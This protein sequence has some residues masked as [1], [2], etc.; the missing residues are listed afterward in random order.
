MERLAP[1]ARDRRLTWDGCL[2]VRDLGG[3]RGPEGAIRRGVLVR[4][5]SMGAPT[6]AGLAAAREHGIRTVI[7]IRGADEI[8]ARPS[9]FAPGATYRQVPFKE[10]AGPMSLHRAAAEGTLAEQLRQRAAPDSGL[11]AIVG[12]IAEAE[13]GLIV[14]C[15]AGRDRTGFVVAIVLA[16]VGVADDDIV[17]DYCASDDELADSYRSYIDAHPD[18][19][20]PIGEAIERRAWVMREVL[21]AVRREYGDGAAYLRSAGVTT[22]QLDRIRAMLLG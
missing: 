13:P 22:E 2:N 21:G 6:P 19:A 18:D 9:P 17:A 20:A 3:L 1:L 16:A 10:A 4:A 15:V 11:A 8:D 14:H 7:D 12:A 5:S